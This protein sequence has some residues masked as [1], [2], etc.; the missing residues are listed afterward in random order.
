[1]VGRVLGEA[2]GQGAMNDPGR[3]PV[4]AARAG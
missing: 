2:V 4:S 1:V 3:E